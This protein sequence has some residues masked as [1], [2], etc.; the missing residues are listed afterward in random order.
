[1]PPLHGS[2]P[3]QKEGLATLNEA[4]VMSRRATQDREFIVKRS[5]KMWS[6]VKGN[7]NPLQHSSLENPMSS[8][9]RQKDMTPE[10]EHSGSESIQNATGESRGQLLIVLERMK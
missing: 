5:N 2:R 4:M 7:G 10:D 9:K 1:M 6:T 3:C 8:M